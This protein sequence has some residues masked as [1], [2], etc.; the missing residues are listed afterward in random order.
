MIKA[1]Q[2]KVNNNL[3][4]NSVEAKIDIKPIKEE[5]NKLIAL[6]HEHN[7]RALNLIIFCLKEEAE[8]NMLG[9]E[10]TCLIE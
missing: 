7:K 4:L 9:I 1:L 3:T 5:M 2:E 10:T 8:D 6:D